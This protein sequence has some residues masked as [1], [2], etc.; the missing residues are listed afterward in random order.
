MPTCYVAPWTS[1]ISGWRLTTALDGTS[2]AR[3]SVPLPEPYRSGE[4]RV[5]ALS[6]LFHPTQW[7]GA[8]EGEGWAA[9]VEFKRMKGNELV[10]SERRQ[11]W[12]GL[13]GKRQEMVS[14]VS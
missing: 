13:G 2:S 11:E 7:R 5:L 3:T 8:L 4:T 9:E 10:P 12:R 1:A 14:L 6:L